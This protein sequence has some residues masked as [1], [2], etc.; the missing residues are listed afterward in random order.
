MATKKPLTAG[1]TGTEQIADADTLIMVGGASVG[2]TSAPAASTILDLVST[3]K[4]FG[5]PAMTSAQKEAITSPRDG[6]FLYDTDLDGTCSYDGVKW[7]RH[8][9]RSI[10]SISTGTG[11]G[12]GASASVVG[13]DIE[14]VVTVTTG[15]SPSTSSTIFT[16]TFADSYTTAPHGALI[17]N[18]TGNLDSLPAG[19]IPGS[20]AVTTTTLTLT[21]A[22]TNGL[23]DATTYKWAYRIIQ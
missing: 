4:A 8:S 14:G 19:R 1:A 2:T 23:S 9:Q 21:N 13:S 3:T 17:G 10:P 5:P 22:A 20:P 18:V 15:T 7:Y 6:C 16:L 11:A 12:T